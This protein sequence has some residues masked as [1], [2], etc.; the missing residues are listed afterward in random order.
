MLIQN[1]LYLIRNEIKIDIQ[2]KILMARSS[3]NSVVKNVVSYK[4]IKKFILI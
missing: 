1:E 4:F 2:E 3:V